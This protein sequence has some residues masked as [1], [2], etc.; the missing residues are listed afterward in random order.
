LD[1]LNG[2]CA[3]E[4]TDKRPILLVID[5]LERI[6]DAPGGDEVR[7]QV[8]PESLPVL[9][10]VLRA[11]CRAHTASRLLLTSRYTFTL[12]DGADDLAGHLF[13][14]Q[15]SPMQP[16]SARLQ[17][18]RRQRSAPVQ[19]DAAAADRREALFQDCI[20]V[21][22]GNPG[23]QDLLFDLALADADAARA[24]LQEMRAYLDRGDLPEQ[25]KVQAFLTDLA[26]DKLIGLAGRGGRELLRRLTVFELPVPKEVATW[27]A[28][29]E[30]SIERLLGLGLCDRCEDLVD[31]ARP[32]TA[33][34]PL[35]RPRAGRLRETEQRALAARALDRL[36]PL[37]DDEDGRRRPF[38]ADTELTRLALLCEDAKVLSACA[39]DAIRWLG[40]QLAYRQAAAWGTHSV[41]ILD[42]AQR[43]PPLALLRE[44]GEASVRVGEVDGARGLFA[45]ALQ[46]VEGDR[47]AGK[48]LD[49]FE[50]SALLVAQARLLVNTG[51]PEQALP[52]FEQARGLAQAYGSERDAA[53]A[54]GDIARLRAQQGEVDEALRLHQEQLA[55][56]ERLSEVR[57]RAVT[58]GD[59]ARLRAQQGEVDEALRLQSERLEVNRRLGGLDG[60]AAALWDMAQIELSRGDIEKAVPMIAEAYQI[61]DR[62]QR[63][64]G[65][66]VIGITF[67][68]NLVAAGEREAGLAVLRRSQEGLRKM[69]Q[70]A[71]ADQVA[72]LIQSIE[73]G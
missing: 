1:L 18:L 62:I 43:E 26:L 19:K 51:E 71:K 13:D 58:L 47:A 36:F 72:A 2:P 55:V 68:Q 6:L 5:D 12:P 65:I 9:R 63:L 39:A 4:A 59:I 38:P 49:P 34:N 54:L 44:A 66:C 20:A 48:D 56:Y 22:Q 28:E 17:A 14:L 35:V 67:G 61:F 11:F 40:E 29:G 53:V 33:V 7:W 42:A 21:A 23:L 64:Y 8:K 52:L 41:E 46:Q 27:L 32:A 15:L 73:N 24:A 3:Q 57:A 31:P 25:E 30:D 69:Q 50:Y 10:A 16:T 37:W 70:H 60:Q 45:R